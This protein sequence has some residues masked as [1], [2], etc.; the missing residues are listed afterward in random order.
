MKNLIYLLLFL[1]FCAEAHATNNLT[2][3]YA[4]TGSVNSGT[5][6]QEAVYTGSTTVGSGLITDNGTNV[7][8]G[9]LLPTSAF[10]VVGNV[11]IGTTG[12]MTTPNTVTVNGQIGLYTEYSNGTL[13]SGTGTI[14]WANG[15]N[16]YI[17]LAATGLT[18]AFTHVTGQ[19][20]GKLQ[21]RVL[22]DG[23]GSRTVTTWPATIKWAGGSAPTLTT[24]A[25]KADIVN[26]FWN[27]TSDY[28]QVAANF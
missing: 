6:N 12:V 21:L 5:T 18:I 15:N 7:G 24:A 9:T 3:T 27:G 23:T 20:S 4:S 2:V 28:C 10:Q 16:Q 8:I 11:S 22:Q 25:N 14:T 1:C 26:C 19:S 17:T 13:S